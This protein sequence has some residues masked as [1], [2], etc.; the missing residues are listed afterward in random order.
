M[1][2]AEGHTTVCGSV[3]FYLCYRNVWLCTREIRKPPP[4]PSSSEWDLIITLLHVDTHSLIVITVC[5]HNPIN[6]FRPFRPFSIIQMSVVSTMKA[7]VRTTGHSVWLC[8]LYPP[9]HGFN[10]QLAL[11]VSP[12]IS[13]RPWQACSLMDGELRENNVFTHTN[14]QNKTPINAYASE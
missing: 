3:S 11:G 14:K 7:F 13:C 5:Y 6:S 4:A 10:S 12:S 2:R 1:R 9:G 8:A